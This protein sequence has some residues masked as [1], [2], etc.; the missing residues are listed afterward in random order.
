MLQIKVETKNGEYILWKP[1]GKVG[2][3]HMSLLLKFYREVI[4]LQNLGS[5]NVFESDIAIEVF[6]EWCEKV[7]P[8]IIVKSPFKYEDIPYSDLMTLFTKIFESAIE[9]MGDVDIE[10]FRQE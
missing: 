7:L 8:E 3:K 2:I 5:E 10:S 4:K 6:E 9:D 1:K